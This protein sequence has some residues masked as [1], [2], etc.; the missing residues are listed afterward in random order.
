MKNTHKLLAIILAALFLLCGCGDKEPEID[1]ESLVVPPVD[2]NITDCISAEQ[3]TTVMG[4]P[5]TLLGT[6]EDGTQAI[7]MS[8]DGLYQTTINLKNEARTVFDSNAAGQ[9]TTPQE[10]LGET[11]YWSAETGELVIYANGYALGVAV[12]MGDL[13]VDTTGYARQIAEIILQK[14]QPTNG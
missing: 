1:Y 4:Q 9:E 11:A 10:G 5:M 14:L 6:F 7:Y 3:V 8:E 12:M 13:D 2:V